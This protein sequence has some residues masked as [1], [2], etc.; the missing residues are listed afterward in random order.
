V[1]LLKNAL[2]GWFVVVI[3]CSDVLNFNVP[4]AS[5]PYDGS[6]MNHVHTPTKAPCNSD[7]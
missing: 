7:V 4:H 3:I 5:L 2:P 6:E 1:C